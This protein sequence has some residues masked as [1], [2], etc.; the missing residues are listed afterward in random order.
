[1]ATNLMKII[2]KFSEDELG[3]IS[4]ALHFHDDWPWEKSDDFF[5]VMLADAEHV[6]FCLEK[7]H[8]KNPQ[9]SEATAIRKIRN[10]LRKYHEQKHDGT[11]S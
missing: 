7:W 2:S 8:E 4:G 11:G 9:P 1:M 6:L 10:H 5:H 3:S